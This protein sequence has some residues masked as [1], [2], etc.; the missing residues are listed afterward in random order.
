MLGNNVK[1][2]VTSAKLFECT[3]VQGFPH[4]RSGTSPNH[5]VECRCVLVSAQNL[6]LFYELLPVGNAKTVVL[7]GVTTV[8]NIPVEFSFHMSVIRSLKGLLCLAQPA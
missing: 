3:D 2:I 5:S 6:Q 8:G 1:P 4:L 7:F